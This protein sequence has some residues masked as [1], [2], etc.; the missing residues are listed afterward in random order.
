VLYIGTYFRVKAHLL[1]ISGHGI[2]ACV[3]V[4]KEEV[5]SLKKLRDEAEARAKVVVPKQVPLSSS[6]SLSRDEENPNGAVIP[7]RASSAKKRA[8]TAME[9]SWD[10]ATRN[11]VDEEIAG[12]FYTGCPSF[13]FAKN[14]HF[15]NSY[16]M[17][18]N[19]GI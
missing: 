17:L 7:K 5:T 14:L 3:K 15:I 2:R 4:T 9:K 8:M 19:S 16:V 10:V 13:N 11:V 1:Q 18:S 6:S 12:G